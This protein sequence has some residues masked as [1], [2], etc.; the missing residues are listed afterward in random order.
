MIFCLFYAQTIIEA[1]YGQKYAQAGSLFAIFLAL[2]LLVRVLGM[3]VHQSTL[4]VLSKAR[5]VVIAQWIGLFVVLALGFWLVPLWGA[6]GALVADGVSRLVTYGLMLV[7]LWR[8][9]PEKYPF[10]YTLRIVLAT[11]GAA[12]VSR[13][14]IAGISSISSTFA[15]HLTG[16][17]L[18]VISG[19]LFVALS[20]LLLAVIRP[21]SRKDLDMIAEVRPG[22][23]RY[24]QWFAQRPLYRSQ[25]KDV[26]D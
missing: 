9:L 14:A 22:V 7:F 3:T 18:L 26:K 19:L 1:I 17:P 10:G 2:N 11:G 21:L 23:A 4:Y 15:H 8:Y 20:A 25:H 12:L 16:K 24:L 5:F 6:A 13:L